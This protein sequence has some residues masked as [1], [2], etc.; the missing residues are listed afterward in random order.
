MSEPAYK[1]TTTGW[2]G[3]H[4]RIFVRDAQERSS[5][6]SSLD[7]NNRTDEGLRWNAA[8]FVARKNGGK[9]VLLLLEEREREEV[10]ELYILMCVMYVIDDD[11]YLIFFWSSLY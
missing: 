8:F 9:V 5:S 10:A 2:E 1:T 3:V 11:A 6:S 4:F 7:V